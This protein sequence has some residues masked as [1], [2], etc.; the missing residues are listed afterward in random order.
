[1]RPLCVGADD[2]VL[3]AALE[4]RADVVVTGDVDLLALEEYEGI[5][6]LAPREFL[7][8]LKR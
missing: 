2:Q 4:G 1:V 8:L 3:G 6:I 5:A 7:D